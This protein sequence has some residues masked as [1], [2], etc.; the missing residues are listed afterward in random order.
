MDA[1]QA[2]E[3]EAR[4]TAPPRQAR[5]S[6][7][8]RRRENVSARPRSIRH[9]TPLVGHRGLA[10]VHGRTQVVAGS[11]GGANYKDEFKLPGTETET[12]STLLRN[13]G[14]DSQNG[15]DGNMALHVND[16]DLT[17]PP[18][19]IV[20]AWKVCADLDPRSSR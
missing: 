6:D 2:P 11:F 20:A 15:I 16:G 5:T 3:N 17:S 12:V 18:A 13:S 14:L 1:C 4:R 10:G 19:R 9:P 8:L 7:P